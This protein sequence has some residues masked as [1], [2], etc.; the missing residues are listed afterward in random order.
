MDS[1]LV[2]LDTRVRPFKLNCCLVAARTRFLGARIQLIAARDCCRMGFFKG[3]NQGSVF[4]NLLA[5]GF[6]LGL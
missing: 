3:S 5:K 6:H 2:R 1:I 4:L